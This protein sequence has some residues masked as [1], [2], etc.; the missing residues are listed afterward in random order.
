MIR[1]VA[2]HTH[3]QKKK[4][5]CTHRMLFW[6]LFSTRIVFVGKLWFTAEFPTHQMKWLEFIW[7]VD[8]IL[9]ALWHTYTK[10]TEYTFTFWHFYH[11]FV[12]SQT[13]TVNI[14]ISNK[15]VC[16]QKK[17]TQIVHSCRTSDETIRYIYWKL[18]STSKL[19]SSDW[20]RLQRKK[21]TYMS[22]HI[23]SY[24]EKF[25]DTWRHSF[26]NTN[27]LHLSWNELNFW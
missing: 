8:W 7:C 24:C 14:H 10:F 27:A 21:L 2:I 19:N 25:S 3:T 26:I 23:I 17:R 6:R 9:T 16:A 20:Q 22:M 12:S 11:S 5:Q 1:Y 4:Q 13:Q 18:P 15:T